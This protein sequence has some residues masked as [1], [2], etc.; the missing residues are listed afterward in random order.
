MPA[1]TTQQSWSGSGR[2]FTFRS[3]GHTAVHHLPPLSKTPT[4]ESNRQ[5]PLP[6]PG[7][8]WP[9]DGG[10]TNP[11][12]RRVPFTAR[13]KKGSAELRHLGGNKVA[14]KNRTAPARR[15]E[16]VES[17]GRVSRAA[18]LPAGTA[19]E[20][21]QT[22]CH[23]PNRHARMTTPS[24]VGTSQWV[25]HRNKLATRWAASKSDQAAAAEAARRQPP[26]LRGPIS[27]AADEKPTIN[28]T[29]TAKPS[30]LALVAEQ[31]GWREDRSPEAFDRQLP[32]AHVVWLVSQEELNKVLS[33]PMRRDNT[34]VSRIPGMHELCRK[35]SFARL[36]RDRG[37]DSG[38]AHL[39]TW[40]LPDERPPPAAFRRGPLIV[41]PDDGSQGSGI[42]VLTTP[43]ELEL[44][45]Q[46]MARKGDGS[47][48][49][50]QYVDRPLL[51]DGY[52]F[53]L[54]LYVLVLS[55]SPLRVFL[56][57][58]G[59][60]RVCSEP[61]LEP[62]DS[63]VREVRLRQNKL[64]RHLTNYGVSK[65]NDAHYDDA[66]D[67]RDG[68][69]GT[70]RTL[71]STF[72]Y[73]EARGEVSEDIWRKICELVRQTTL[74]M[75]RA[76]RDERTEPELRLEN[77]WERS[78]PRSGWP[79]SAGGA[80]ST[81]EP[82]K[83]GER[84]HQDCFQLLGLDII[85]EEDGTPHILEANCGPSFGFDKIDVVGPSPPKP[86]HVPPPRPA[87]L[88]FTPRG[89]IAMSTNGNDSGG[90]STVE[91]CQV[92]SGGSS[93]SGGGGGGGT[94]SAEPVVEEEEE[95]EEE[96]IISPELVASRLR[97]FGT[98]VCRCS[99]TVK[100]HVHRP[101]KVD[102]AVKGKALKGLCE[103]LRRDIH[104]RSHTDTQQ[105]PQAGGAGG[106]SS[107]SSHSDGGGGPTLDSG[108]E[109]P[110]ADG[111][112]VSS[113]HRD[114]GATD[115]TTCASTGIWS[116]AAKNQ[117]AQL[118]DD[119]DDANNNDDNDDNENDDHATPKP[120][121]EQND[122]VA[123]E[124]GQQQHQHREEETAAATVAPL[125]AAAR[126]AA[127]VEGT[128]YAVIWAGD[129]DEVQPRAR[130]PPPH[131]RP[132]TP[133]EVR[134]TTNH[135][136]PRAHTPPQEP[137]E[138]AAACL[139][140]AADSDDDVLQLPRRS[141]SVLPPLSVSEPHRQSMLH[142]PG[143]LPAAGARGEL[144]LPHESRPASAEAQLSPRP[145]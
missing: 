11:G 60:V 85:L 139:P 88:E 143:R 25:R 95:E 31:L 96:E 12:K 82:H 102:L 15:A 101:C 13:N 28:T 90:A 34:R 27:L 6:L 99:A 127:L 138:G 113:N 64:T 112:C 45:L 78:G 87:T 17:A 48:V 123:H 65:H 89:S 35:V 131:P 37:I 42:S 132:N 3:Q 4:G 20:S 14:R 98:K 74:E 93:S 83:V 86:Y 121:D 33:S 21:A 145:C 63:T 62:T 119:D 32:R 116:M 51:V 130:L 122:G 23:P 18:T 52:K 1:G 120:S 109:S 84:E 55:L 92:A 36:L 80:S 76:C 94:G 50:Q 16:H 142:G 117:A 41:K 111:E 53:D 71:S 110:V 22:S 56:C 137:A 100:P 125:D 68:S 77:L 135:K 57:K 115:S 114:G 140:R 70:K 141:A 133:L 107:V 9:Q 97:G 59:L 91:V 38:D 44:M 108:F 30:T 81:W 136:Q 104:A 39:A 54:R 67:P 26:P 10:T 8:K 106:A 58:E 5:A 126:A 7:H 105:Q 43:V 72:E 103:I 66:D 2:T 69:R 19:H 47:A 73:L 61:Y 134:C 46:K 40:V 144:P 128:A 118:Q 24:E 49:A 129:E 79:H 75:G 29:K 124:Q